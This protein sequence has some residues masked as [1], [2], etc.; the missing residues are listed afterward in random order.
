MA[1][2]KLTR[3]VSYG[4]KTYTPTKGGDGLTEVPDDVAGILLDRQQAGA[5]AFIEAE[6]AAAKAARSTPKAPTPKE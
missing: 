6:A 4:G 3:E 2:I 1:R 5:Q